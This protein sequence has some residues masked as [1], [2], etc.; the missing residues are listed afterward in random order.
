MLKTLLLAM[1]S[2]PETSSTAFNLTS[3]NERLLSENIEISYNA[4]AFIIG[5]PVNCWALRRYYKLWKMKRTNRR[6]L[7]GYNLTIT[8]LLILL[9]YCPTQIAWLITVSWPW[10]ET[11]CKIRMFLCVLVYHLSSNAVVIIA[12]EM[13]WSLR[14]PFR[15]HSE[16]GSSRYWVHII[17][18]ILIS[19]VCSVP[20]IITWGLTDIPQTDLVQ[21]IF[22]YSENIIFTVA[23]EFIHLSTVFYVPLLII[24]VCYAASGYV[25]WKQL[26]QRKLLLHEQQH[27]LLIETTS[28]AYR[29]NRRSTTSSMN[30]S[31]QITRIK[32]KLIRVSATV[33]SSYIL[34]WLP[35]QV[36]AIWTTSQKLQIG[37]SLNATN[38]HND[39]LSEYINWL[40]AL[41][42]S[43][44]CINPFLYT[45]HG[46]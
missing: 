42:I 5:V 39:I 20:Q 23:Y 10:G 21:C 31:L 29:K 41:M 9:F 33:I 24:I 34:C 8:N 28:C 14:K 22:L 32:W 15:V 25:L 2:S 36:L 17:F 18:S 40:E 43:S 27:S 4:L 13:F 45:Y 11:V 6:V 19:V 3:F 35:Y 30:S 38:V 1:D 16:N 46:L 12:L 26:H 44:A 37:W 7:L